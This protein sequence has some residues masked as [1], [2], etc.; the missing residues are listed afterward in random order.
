MLKGLKFFQALKGF[1]DFLPHVQQDD[2]VHIQ[3]QPPHL[4]LG[5]TQSG[6]VA[7]VNQKDEREKLLKTEK[8]IVKD[9]SYKFH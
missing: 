8:K 7:K 5:S 4:S 3:V 9:H 6:V 2:S 1:L